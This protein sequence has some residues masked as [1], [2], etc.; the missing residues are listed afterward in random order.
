MNDYIEITGVSENNLKHF[1]IK[2]P[3]GKLVVLA[4]VSGSGKSSLA[5]DKKSVY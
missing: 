3:K 4:G 1:N 2:I 5:F